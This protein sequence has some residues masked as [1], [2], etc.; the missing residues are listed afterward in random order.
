MGCT[1]TVMVETRRGNITIY[2]V[3][4]LPPETINSYIDKFPAIVLLKIKEKFDGLS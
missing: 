2:T 4:P 3:V 1:S